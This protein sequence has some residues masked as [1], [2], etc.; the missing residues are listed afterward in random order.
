MDMTTPGYSIRSAQ[1]KHIP[2][3]SAI[4][5]AAAQLLSGYAPE[6][7][8]AETTNERT[9][10]DA[11]RDGRLWVASTGDMPVGFALVKNARG[12]PAPSRRD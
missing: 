7:V 4:E 5:L 10:A 1:A 9:F 6:S 2:A 11:A 8:L 3:L 12:R